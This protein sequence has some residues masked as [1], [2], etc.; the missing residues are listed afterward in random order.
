MLR[1]KQSIKQIRV[2]VSRSETRIE[3]K[4]LSLFEPPTEVLR[5]GNAA[6]PSKFGKMVKLQEAE[7]QIAMDCEIYDRWPSNSDWLIAGTEIYETRLGCS[8]RLVAADAAFYSSNKL[9]TFN[10]QWNARMDP[11]QLRKAYRLSGLT[12]EEFG[13]P[14]YQRIGH[15]KKLCGG[16]PGYR[17]AARPATAPWQ[18]RVAGRIGSRRE[19]LSEPA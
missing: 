9:P 14:R 10:P 3:G 18:C 12:L 11:D 7:N 6:K 13:G 4:L 17:I 2:R 19:A 15:I 1:V 8:P 5:K 16:R